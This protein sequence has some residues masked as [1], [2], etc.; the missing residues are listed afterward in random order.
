MEVPA[1]PMPWPQVSIREA[2]AEVAAGFEGV[3]EAVLAASAT[4]E[5]NNIIS[6]SR[7]HSP[8]HIIISSNEFHSPP[9]RIISISSSSGLH[10]APRST[11]SSSS[12]RSINS[13]IRSSGRQTAPERVEA[14]ACLFL[15]RPARAALLCKVSSDASRAPEHV[16]PAP[17]YTA[18]QGDPQ[19][20]LSSTYYPGDYASSWGEDYGPSQKQQ[21]MPSPPVPQ[22]PPVP[23]DPSWN[24]PADR[25]GMTQFCP[26]SESV[27][28]SGIVSNSFTRRFPAS[29]PRPFSSSYLPSA[30]AAQSMDKSS[31]V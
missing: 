18:Q 20:F 13:N 31:D 12:R 15:L 3:A 28:P 10:S 8:L 1:A 30:F 14:I 6:S 23:S 27:S 9:R 7:L 5:A 17:S 25:A 4:A 29:V 2:T 21:Q 22:G 26:P 11:S 16:S 24:F 19:I